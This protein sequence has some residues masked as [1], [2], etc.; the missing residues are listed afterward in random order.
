MNLGELYRRVRREGD[1]ENAFQLAAD[2]ARR[3]RPERS[4]LL[5]EVLS[6]LGSLY[7]ETGRPEAAKAVLAQALDR[8]AHLPAASPAEVAY[9]RN[10]MGMAQLSF[11]LNKEAEANLRSAVALASSSLGD[12]DPETASY[13]TNL[14]LCFIVQGQYRSAIA[15]L[16]RAKLIVEARWGPSDGHSGLILAELSAALLGDNKLGLAEEYARQA[17]DI[18]GRN[19]DSNPTVMALVQVNLADVLLRANKLDEADQFLPATVATE[20]QVAANTRLLADGIRRLAD[21]RAMQRCWPQ[22]QELYMEAI[23][24]YEKQLGPNSPALAPVL[25][26]YAGAL[27]HNGGSKSDVRNLESRARTIASYMPRT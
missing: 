1:A 11:D 17:I 27:K 7:Q 12:S 21:L 22:A 25:R 15:L 14:A 19:K 8:F 3:V 13:Q 20:R 9:A 24:I 23:T 2:L 10:A 6:R 4:E 16:R 18:L 5:P 26:G